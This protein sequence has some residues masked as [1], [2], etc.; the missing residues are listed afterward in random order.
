MASKNSLVLKL[1]GPEKNDCHLAL[2][3]FAEKLRQFNVF[4]TSSAKDGNQD[5]TTFQ[6]VNLS[7]SSPAM[8][9]CKPIS[10]NLLPTTGTIIQI[11][12]D[13]DSVQSNEAQY[14]SNTALSALEN[15]ARFDQKKIARAEIQVIGE[16]SEVYV[17]PLNDR[18]REALRAARDA[19]DRVI[20]TIDGKLEQINIHKDQNTFRIYPDL[21]NRPAVV[22]QFP[23]QLLTE[24]Q[25]ALGRFVSVRGECFYRPN[26]AFAYRITVQEMTILPPDSELPS[27]RDLYGIAPD[28][29]GDK[30]TEQFVRQLRDEWR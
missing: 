7:H 9:E 6:V 17:Y 8:L 19:E 18:F 27:L 13:L 5:R 11:Q 26:A 1:E 29:T 24:V 4:L 22:C 15:L 10:E 16:E 20:S 23:A 12:Q 21:P 3:V 2:S 30:T 25:K 14:L 28:A